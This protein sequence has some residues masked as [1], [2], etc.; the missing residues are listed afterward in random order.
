M[1]THRAADERSIR[2]VDAAKDEKPNPSEDVLKIQ[3]YGSRAN[4][5]VFIVFWH[6]QGRNSVYIVSHLLKTFYILIFISFSSC[7]YVEV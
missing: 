3:N 6:N 4:K 7:C 2:T 1:M 5:N